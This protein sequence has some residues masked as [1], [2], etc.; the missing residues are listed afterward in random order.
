MYFILSL[1]S[2]IA[3]LA[4]GVWVTKSTVLRACGSQLGGILARSVN[5]R[6]KALLMGLCTTMLVQSS[7]ATSLLVSSFLN[8]GVL[9]LGT[10]LVIMLG[11]DLGTAVMARILTCDLSLLC[12][13]LLTVGTVLHLSLRERPR[14]RN[15]GGI[16]LGLGLILLALSLIV[17]ATTPVINSELTALLLNSLTGELTFSLLLGMALAVICYSSLAAVLLTSLLCASGSVLPDSALAV[18]IG[19]NLGSCM[20]EIL[21]ALSQGNTAKRV[22]LGNTF[23]KLII[24]LIC[25][26]LLPF[27][28]K[29]QQQSINLSSFVIWFHVFFNAL[30]CLTMLPL[31]GPMSKFL[32]LVLPKK[33]PAPDPSAPR[34]LDKNAYINPNLALVNASRE[35]LRL[36]DFMQEMFEN[37]A[38]SIDNREPHD[39][40]NQELRG[41]IKKVAEAISDYLPGISPDS[42]KQKQLLRQCLLASVSLNECA[43]LAYVIDKRVLKLSQF[44]PGEFVRADKERLHKIA[45][46]SALSIEYALNAF[47]YGGQ[48]HLQ[49]FYQSRAEFSALAAEFGASRLENGSLND[50]KDQRVNMLLLEILGHFRQMDTMFDTLFQGAPENRERSFP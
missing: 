22:M 30:V 20:L 44:F 6:L 24:G 3:L 42:E 29:A 4:Y 38:L 32:Y 28:I 41:R 12:P 15:F 2:A 43:Q 46:A 17:K 18:V 5:S 37:L 27:F 34:H 36:G 7:T 10:A 39:P 13:L 11:A 16:C 1:L 40:S 31:V 25:L 26:P 23:F 48:E 45:G 50:E 14:L 35:L 21:G 47:V 8:K 33:E 9:T 49:S 19:A